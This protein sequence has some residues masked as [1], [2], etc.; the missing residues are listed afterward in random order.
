MSNKGFFVSVASVAVLCLFA[1]CEKT[2]DWIIIDD[3]EDIT[4]TTINH[5][6][7]DDYVWDTNKVIH[8]A[9][10]GNSIS[11]DSTGATIDGSVVTIVSA[12]TYS[13]SGSLDEGQIVVNTEDEGTVRLILAGVTIHNSTTAPVYIQSSDKTILILADGSENT[14]TDGTAYV[15]E[16][17]GEEEPNAAIYSK[18]DL[19][20]YGNGSLTVTGSYADGITSKD[21]LII[22]SGSVTV[23]SRDDGIRGKDYLVV[24]G[25]N[26][27]VKSGGDGFKS[28]NDEDPLRGYISIEAGSVNITSG[29]DAITAQTNAIVTG[30][31]INLI[32]GGGSGKTIASTLSAKAIKA[33]S[34]VVL[35]AGTFNINSADDAL[36]TNGAM[37]INGGTFII[38]TADDGVHADTTLVI[39]G[40]SFKINKCYEGLESQAITINLCDIYINASDDA[41]NAADGT[42]TDGMGGGMGGGFGGGMGVGMTAGTCTF[43]MNGGYITV[44]SVGDGMDINGSVVMTGGTLIVDGPTVNDN[45]AV[46]YDGTFTISGGFLLATGSAGMAQAPGTSS[47]QYSILMSFQS[48]QAAKTLIHLQ[49]S[50]GTSLFTYAPVKKYQSVAFSS[51]SLV[52][53]TTYEIYSGGTVTGTSNDGLYMDGTYTAG[54]KTVNFTV[55]GIVTKV[56]GR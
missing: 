41:I 19:T 20:I 25:G 10:D 52:K 7:A 11:I 32:S 38:S 33:I 55:S 15:F 8:I 50:D 37:E 42:A 44:H 2:D 17:A 4:I 28:D 23:T 56:T 34:A 36:H 27:T 26:I 22:K 43:T 1:A 12:G 6:E 46:D 18:S 35:D 3:G 29:G 53:G 54:T 9:F 30:G 5:E 45:G 47:S 40:G 24:R 51:S 21:G 48:I 31:E 13:F 39:N 16:T 49:S 14:V